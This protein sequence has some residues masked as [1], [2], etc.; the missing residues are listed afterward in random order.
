M[1]S[2]RQFLGQSLT[3]S[4]P[5]LAAMA[6]ATIPATAFARSKPLENDPNEANGQDWIGIQV[7]VKFSGRWT[8]ITIELDDDNYYR[9]FDEARVF[10]VHD[11]MADPSGAIPLGQT[12]SFTKKRTQKIKVKFSEPVSPGDVI[13]VVYNGPGGADFL[14]VTLVNK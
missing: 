12:V 11:P 3:G 9:G 2:R 4:F 6:L 1:T 10:L 5:A 7:D 8:I 13:R 14:D